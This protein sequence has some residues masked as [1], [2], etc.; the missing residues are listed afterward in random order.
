MKSFTQ[1]RSEC[2][3]YHCGISVDDRF[4]NGKPGGRET[5]ED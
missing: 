2:K 3:I 4:K 1:E 5:N